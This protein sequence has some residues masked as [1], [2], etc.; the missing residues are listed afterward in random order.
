[1]SAEI[2]AARLYYIEWLD[3]EL[4]SRPINWGRIQ[5][6]MMISQQGEH[7]KAAAD[8]CQYHLR[9]TRDPIIW[10]QIDEIYAR[11]M[12]IYTRN[13]RSENT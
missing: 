11:C 9:I 13:R 8:A 2:S 1:M 12:Y 7:L 3:S 10:A 6:F 5:Y 4:C